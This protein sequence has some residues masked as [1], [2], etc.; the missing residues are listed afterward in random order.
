MLSATFPCY[1]HAEYVEQPLDALTSQW[2]PAEE[3]I[4]IDDALT[5]ASITL[6]ERY[7]TPSCG[8]AA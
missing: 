5:D 4:V 3:T 1:N 8:R 2:R 6:I 7:G